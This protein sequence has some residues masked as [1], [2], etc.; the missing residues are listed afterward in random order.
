MSGV[1]RVGTA[2]AGIAF[3]LSAGGCKSAFVEADVKN[4]T[5]GDVTL[6]EVDYPSASFGKEALPAGA[7]FHQRFKIL[8]NG[9]TTVS[10]TDAKKVQHSVKG[11]ELREG[12]DGT[13][14]IT[15]SGDSAPWTLGLKN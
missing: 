15:L 4:Q 11:P 13:V 7:T 5:G 3:V 8:G 12:Q 6:V 14:V 1:W 10:W 2:V 9:G